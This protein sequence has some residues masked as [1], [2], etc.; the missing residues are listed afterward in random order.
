MVEDG[1]IKQCYVD[2]YTS[3][4]FLYENYLKE[5]KNFK[6]SKD[7]FNEQIDELQENALAK[8]GSLGKRKYR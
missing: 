5:Y 8:R 3:K 2:K 4:E 7:K 1:Q 6:T